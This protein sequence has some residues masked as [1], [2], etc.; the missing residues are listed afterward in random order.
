MLWKSAG[1]LLKLTQTSSSPSQMVS[2]KGIYIELLNEAKLDCIF[3]DNIAA[4]NMDQD[5]LHI[6]GSGSVIPA[7]NLISGIRNFWKK[8]TCKKES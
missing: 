3:N 1:S 4:P 8:G 7:K 2:I 5:G 6:N